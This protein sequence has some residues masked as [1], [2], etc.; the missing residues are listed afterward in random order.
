[1]KFEIK[2]AAVIGAGVMGSGI[3][4]HLANVG[5]PTYL[6]DIVPN[7]LTPE[8]EQK[9][10][11]LEDTAVRNRLTVNAK[12]AMLKA[13]P[14]PLYQAEDAELI[15]VGNITDNLDYLSD[16]DWIIEV[17]VE[18]LNIKKALFESIEKYRK[19]GAI[20]SSNT[21]GVSINEMIVGRSE[22]LKKHFLG[23]HFFNPPRYMKLLEIIPADDTDPK[24]LEFMI[25]F[26]ERVLGKGVVLAKDTPNFIA[27]RIGTYGLMVTVHEMERM[28]L[29]VDEVDEITGPLMGRPKSASFRTLDMVGLDTFVHVANNVLENSDDPVDKSAFTMPQFIL[30]M[31]G[32]G[33]IGDKNKQGF[34]KKVKTDKGKEILVL[35]H[36][37]M[38]YV[39]KEKIKSATV[40]MAKQGKSLKDKLI[41]LVYGKDQAGLFAWNSLKKVL[42]Y[43]ANKLGEIADDIVNIDNAMKWGF[44]WELGPFEIWD[45]IGLEKSV[46]RMKEEG[47]QIPEFVINL[48]ENDRKSFY[49]EKETKRFYFSKSG[50]AEEIAKKEEIIS[51]AELKKQNKV[52]KSNSGASLI[53]MGNDV[54]LLEFHS[55]NNAIASDIITMINQSV[56]EVSNNYRGLIIG[57]QSKNFS[58]GANLML[59]LMEAQDENWDDID[60]MVRMFQ[61]ASLKLK[62]MNKPVVTAPFGMT[63]GGGAE[64]TFGGDVVQAAAETYMGLVEVGVGV[65]PAGGGT[66]E[67]LFRNLEGVP[68]DLKI[69][70][71]LFVNR[72]FETIAM[73]KVATSAKEAQ[74]FGYLRK[75]DRISINKDYQLSDAKK[76]VLALDS[77]GYQAPRPKKIRVIGESGFSTLRLGIYTYNVG[78]MISDHDKKIA[79]KLAFVLSGGNLPANSIVSEQYILDLEREAF[80]SLVGEPK[81]QARMQYMLTKNK[82]LRN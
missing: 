52:I 8:E 32:K 62:Y 36:K 57:N 58:V 17:V 82:P 54:A 5:I 2:K 67:M 7:K 33:L 20:V 79:E 53:D 49:E 31:V 40:E 71:Q 73:A 6:L 30:D 48:L 75:T 41:T 47:D 22:D 18:N 11:S 28:G 15:T 29:R 25:N 27:N 68:D 63:L 14:S 61:D 60:L 64:I 35:D 9:G 59:I 23:T 4:A 80:L 50:T 46:A 55:P 74:K 10:L 76:A 3:A 37:T 16:A 13:K 56:E 81:T 45:A 51:L 34:Y 21:S 12:K 78:G 38:E 70:L 66:K 39:P 43:S 77:M 42:L 72:A 44:N 19:Q 1:M 24:V 26:A 69:D 65:I